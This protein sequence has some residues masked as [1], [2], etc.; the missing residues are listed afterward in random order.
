MHEIRRVL[1]LLTHG[2]VCGLALLIGLLALVGR[3]MVASQERLHRWGWHVAGVAFLAFTVQGFVA[4][5]S[6]DPEE[7]LLVAVRGLLAGGL[8][9]AV[10]WLLLPTAAFAYR[11]TV[12][13]V[14]TGVRHWC[15]AEGGRMARRRAR[16]ADAERRRRAQEAFERDAP[17]RERLLREAEREG[18]RQAEAQRRR[19]SAR[20]NCELLYNL[21]AP[22]IKGRF[23]RRQFDAFVQ[24]YMT[25]AHAPEYV[26]A[27][28]E[29]LAAIIEQHRQKIE[30]P[31]KRMSLAELAEWFLREKRQ[32]D[33][34]PLDDEDKEALTAQL[35]ARYAK[36]QE[37][38]IRS[39]EP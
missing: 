5:A 4:S 20:A 22:E 39:M 35:E 29:Q 36:L 12:G 32:I 17:E 3:K 30:P 27:R 6:S 2:E 37:K 9:L 23:G 24:K 34:A 10:S 21:C 14:V 19:E 33:D 31:K 26:E 13:A 28:A 8:A 18:H 11:L 15:H 16:R 7:L 1:E 25:D 38:H